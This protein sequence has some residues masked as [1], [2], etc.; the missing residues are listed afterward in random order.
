MEVFH[1]VQALNHQCVAHSWKR[2][3]R[4]TSA[5][6]APAGEGDRLLNSVAFC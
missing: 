2:G 4:A 6:I 1:F 3:R 5:A